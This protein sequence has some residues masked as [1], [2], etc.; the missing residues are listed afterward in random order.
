M[1][2]K[3]RL[4]V[5]VLIIALLASLISACTVSDNK[6]DY[7][8]QDYSENEAPPLSAGSTEAG[9]FTAT[10]S[11]V[12]VTKNDKAL[13]DYSNTT[14]G[15]VM[16]KYL[17]TNTKVKTQVSCPSGITYTY[18]QSLSG[19]YDVYPLSEGS[20][21]YSINIY[22]NTGGTSYAMAFS[23][24]ISVNLKDEFAP[25]L[26]SN[27]YVNYSSSSKV[28][29]KSI[30]LCKNKSDTLAKIKAIYEFVITNFTYDYQ[31][32]KSVQSG[33]IPDLD[34]VMDKKKGICFDYAAVMTAM[35]RY[36]GIPT[37][38]VFGYT[39]SVYHAWILTYSKDSGWISTAIYFNGNEWKL[40]DP[41]FA[42]TAN[43]S[44]KIMK[45]IENGANYT[46]KYLY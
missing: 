18:N 35:L 16:L 14:D 37:K 42:S 40:M 19:E 7:I 38:L 32:A 30:E 43:S 20:G 21:S 27:K 28:V 34:S 1:K 3:K 13:L 46:E 8:I 36:Q 17:G 5:P 10:A 33:Y 11:G 25:F 44:A 9:P 41:T 22:E 29:E 6:S 26:R 12:L 31:L 24:T 23:F 15:Y 45:Y 4:S 2:T 39:G